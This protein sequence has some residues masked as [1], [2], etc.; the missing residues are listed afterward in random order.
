M[1]FLAPRLLLDENRHELAEQ[2]AHD[3]HALL[4]CGHVING[5][6][7]GEEYRLDTPSMRRVV[8]LRIALRDVR[9]SDKG[10]CGLKRLQGFLEAVEAGDTAEAEL[11]CLCQFVS[12]CQ[13]FKERCRIPVDILYHN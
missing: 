2:L 4:P 10:G 12:G 8:Q 1:F 7:H 6:A 9:D 5:M 11:V 13:S 3:V